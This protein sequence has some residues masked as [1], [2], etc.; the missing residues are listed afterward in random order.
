MAS[1]DLHMHST[2]SNDGEFTPKQ[3]VSL[4]LQAGL[5]HSAIADH[6]SV[7][8]IPEA[9]S[10]A[11]GT[12]MIIIPAVELDCHINGTILHLLGYGIDHTNPIF[13]EL[14]S[15]LHKQEQD[16][17]AELMQKVR[18]L[19]IDFDDNFIA[20]LAFDGVIT[21]EMIAEAALLHDK[22]AQNPLLDPYREDGERSDNPFVNF[23]WDHCSQGKPAFVAMNYMSLEEAIELV[24]NNCGAAILAHPGNNVKED[25]VLLEEIFH[26]D[27]QGLEA[28]SSY[29]NPQ[30]ISFYRVYAETHG[31]LITCGSD[32]H[33]KTKKN[34]K[35]GSSPCDGLEAQM[36]DAL[37]R[38]IDQRH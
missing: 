3:L 38:A 24:H 26:Q 30:Q 5:T 31:L 22:K 36:I 25:I 33:G 18:D 29:H 32:F 12:G 8:G 6:N 23:Y 21:P 4:C 9:L 13:V 16:N 7:G 19:G 27:V 37:M 15:T 34:I 11:K 2:F 28:F 1:I 10:A 17:S 14:E 35:L 20:T